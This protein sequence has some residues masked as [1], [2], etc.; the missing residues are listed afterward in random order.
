MYV[1]YVMKDML[2]QQ[3]HAA[4]DLICTQLLMLS[5]WHITLQADQSCSCKL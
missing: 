1:A 2:V 5:V 3:M 4:Q